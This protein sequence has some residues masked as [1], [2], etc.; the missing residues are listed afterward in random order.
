MKGAD[1]TTLALTGQV[2]AWAAYR[3]PF[4]P[5]EALRAVIGT[6][7]GA[8]PLLV[9][10]VLAALRSDCVILPGPEGERW[11]L[12]PGPRRKQLSG[13]AGTGDAPD[14]P[15]V[16]D[17][18][19]APDTPVARALRGQAP[20]GPADLG[21]L[22]AD[23]GPVEA[24]RDAVATLDRAGPGAPGYP[25]LTPLRAA[26]NTGLAVR[27]SDEILAPGFFGREDERFRIAGWIARPQ[28]EPPLR[29]LHISGLPGMGK[30]YLLEQAIREARLDRQPLILR[31]DFDRAALDVRDG[32]AFFEELS[33]QVADSL[34]EAA[35]QLQ[36]ARLN[37]AQAKVSQS[38]RG[39]RGRLPRALI[40]ATARALRDS[41]RM[42]LVVLDTLEML[43]ARGETDM[44]TLFEHLDQLAKGAGPV[45]ILSAGR[46]DAL[47]PVPERLAGH[48]PLLG[49]EDA[50][51][52]AILTAHGIAPG[53]W[54]AILPLARGNPL[55][56]TLAGKAMTGGAF[57]AEGL[58]RAAS[59]ETIGGYLY[60]AILSRVPARLRRI[61]NEGLILRHIDRDMLRRIVAPALG[62]ALTASEAGQI[63]TELNDQHW[64]VQRDASGRT[65]H[66]ADVRRAF[67]PLIYADSPDDCAAIDA[68]AAAVLD[69]SDP[70]SALYHRLQLF[71]ATGELPPV[72]AEL[73]AGFTQDMLDDLIPRA[74]DAVLQAQGRRSQYRRAGPPPDVAA[75]PPATLPDA[76]ADARPTKASATAAPR[77]RD[78]DGAPLFFFDPSRRRVI[79]ASAANPAPP[80]QPDPRGVRDLVNMLRSGA[81]REAAHVLEH[82]LGGAFTA[83]SEAGRTVM[84]F[85]WVGGRWGAARRLADACA[86]RDANG[87]AA[88]ILGREGPERRF[89]AEMMAEFRCDAFTRWLRSGDHHDQIMQVRLETGRQGVEGMA[90]DMALIA[91][92]PDL[93]ALAG[94]R[95]FD[96][97]LGVLAP[98]LE[99]PL[100]PQL[101]AALRRGWER[102]QDQGLTLLPWDPDPWQDM[103]IPPDLDAAQ[104]L[105]LPARRMAVLNPVEIPLQACLMSEGLARAVPDHLTAAAAIT[106]RL[107]GLAGMRHD[108]PDAAPEA[109]DSFDARAPASVAERFATLGLTADWLQGFA[110]LHP[111]ADLP[112]LA[113][114]AE[115]WR[116]TAA[117]LWSHGRQPPHGWRG[118]GGA[119]AVAMLR[120]RELLAGDDGDLATALLIWAQPDPGADPFAAMQQLERRFQRRL[121]LAVDQAA[122]DRGAADEGASDGGASDGALRAALA[123]LQASGVPAVFAA[124]LAVMATRRLTIMDVFSGSSAYA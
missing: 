12:R 82:A 111:I 94:P 54:P 45:Q 25:L 87:I 37:S 65:R 38:G 117:G 50:A 63:L 31:L 113:H 72:P 86:P 97:P 26:L 47:D 106:A 60:R 83:A 20:Y 123:G 9:A 124:P 13:L 74:R 53:L 55:L 44:R 101:T 85:L 40:G 29:T 108:A 109:S 58:P 64:L 110:L 70:L 92:A 24:L 56:L 1:D 80:G 112:A 3:G 22:V 27:R 28:H 19:D 99:A 122:A 78:E 17:A 41:G 93:A 14:T 6:P 39:A 48:V 121:S 77:L 51:A 119:D 105:A 84:D 62:L 30:S 18:P 91:A 49:L 102:R 42:L 98:W 96:L 114:A 52:R 67:L 46:G 61:A 107:V 32:H 5:A 35:M 76:P 81:E 11:D 66:R 79:Q 23:A 8:D 100:V 71:R 73:A 43:R 116:R 4:D 104:R 88:F 16:G 103:V 95:A 59:D 115:R 68:R 2:R 15:E 120:A 118:A 90:L 36:Q 34:P 75:T 89:A 21:A 10:R 33:R 57:D 7:V 69:D